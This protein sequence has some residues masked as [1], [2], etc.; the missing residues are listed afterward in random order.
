MNRYAG[1][2]LL[3]CVDICMQNYVFFSFFSFAYDILPISYSP[4]FHAIIYFFLF[5]F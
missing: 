1:S 5:D 3:I 2:I 4:Y